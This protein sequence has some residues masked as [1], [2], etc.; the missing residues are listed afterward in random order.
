MVHATIM[1]F[2][3]SYWDADLFPKLKW[4]Y[5]TLFVPAAI[6]KQRGLTKTPSLELTELDPF[7]QMI[8]QVAISYDIKWIL[9]TPTSEPALQFP[10]LTMSDIHF[11]CMYSNTVGKIKSTVK[12]GLRYLRGPDRRLDNFVHATKLQS[13]AFLYVL[14][15]T[16]SF[17]TIPKG[18]KRNYSIFITIKNSNIFTYCSCKNGQ[19]GKCSHIAAGLIA[20]MQI[21]NNDFSKKPNFVE[22]LVKKYP[23][24]MT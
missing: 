16:A 22:R 3:K 7:S 23:S 2:Q 1:Q 8:E 18:G 15:A 24:L 11:I 10:S 4:T 13:G 17:G 12:H 9:V 6:L 19:S 5:D 20:L 21:K 14:D